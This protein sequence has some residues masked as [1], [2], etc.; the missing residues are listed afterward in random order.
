MTRPFRPGKYS[1][2]C[3]PAE[4]GTAKLIINKQTGQW[5]TQYDKSQDLAR[6]D[7]KKGTLEKPVDQFTMAIEAVAAEAA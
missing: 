4:D 5:G 1:L 6:V 3:L 2:L 7:M